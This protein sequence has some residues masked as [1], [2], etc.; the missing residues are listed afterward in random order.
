MEAYAVLKILSTVLFKNEQK[1]NQYF[2]DQAVYGC[3]DGEYVIGSGKSDTTGPIVQ[4]NMMGYA[5]PARVL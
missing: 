5:N 2:T 1:C 4:V 3:F